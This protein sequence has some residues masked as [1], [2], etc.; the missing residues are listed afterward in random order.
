MSRLSILRQMMTD[1]AL[2]GFLVTGAENRRYLSGFTGSYAA[3]LIGMDTADLLTDFRYKD[4]ARVEAPEFNLRTQGKDLWISLREVIQELGWKRVGF[5][6]EQLTVK[7][8]T[9]LTSGFQGIIWV[10]IADGVSRLRQVKDSLEIE[11]IRQA[12][13]LTDRVWQTVMPTIRPGETER[14]VAFR[15]ETELRRLGAEG[16]AFTTIV[17]SGPRG[18]LPHGTASERR[19]ENGDLVTVDFGC[20]LAGYH[21]DMTRTVA[22]GDA[23]KKQREIYELVLKAQ[24]YA[25]SNL[26]PGMKGKDGDALA[27]DMIGDAGFGEYFGHGLG[28]S[29]GLEIHES[30]RLSPTEEIELQAGMVLTVEPGIYL[31]DWGGVRIEDVVVLT[32]TGCEVLT[33]SDKRFTIIA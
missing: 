15:L 26:R 7:D 24:E 20:R 6:P 4:Q 1:E 22:L 23:V 3:L 18:A 31:P 25:I 29:L 19:L 2:D 12:I 5:E 17:A 11:S 27:R 10:A 33:A 21:S 13:A 9:L 8:F 28:H 16:M 32:D 30:P 14:D